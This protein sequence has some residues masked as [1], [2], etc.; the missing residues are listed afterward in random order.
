[1][2]T[3]RNKKSAVAAS[4]V[5][6]EKPKAATRRSASSHVASMADKRKSKAESK[7]ATVNNKRTRKLSSDNEG[8]T[9]NET[10]VQS[11]VSDARA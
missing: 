5:E 4:A 7:V 3:R 6:V 2:S 1:M 9:A 10:T 8:T 11:S